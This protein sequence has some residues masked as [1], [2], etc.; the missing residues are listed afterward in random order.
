MAFSTYNSFQRNLTTIANSIYKYIFAVDAS[1]VLYYPFDTST[2]NN[3]PN[4]ASGQPVYDATL[5][6][7]SKITTTQ[8]TYITSIAD[9]SLNNI[10]GSTASDYVI[11]SN[12]ITLVPSTGLS[13]SCWFSCSGQ[14]NTNQT[15]FSLPLAN[16]NGINVTISNMNTINSNL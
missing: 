16:T 12:T 15:L 7:N 11:A 13:I 4:Y 14:L 5:I 2:S 9:L 8:N 3:T 10:A 1:L 6:G